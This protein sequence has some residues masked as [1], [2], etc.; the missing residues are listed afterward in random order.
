MPVP[1]V[2]LLVQVV[3][4]NPATSVAVLLCLNTYDVTILRQLHPVLLHTVTGVTWCDM[5][6]T[7]RDVR[8][9]RAALPAAEGA[10]VVRLF[11]DTLALLAR[12]FGSVTPLRMC[13][14][15]LQVT[16]RSALESGLPAP[17]PS[18]L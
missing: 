13:H 3:S 12:L 1:D 10:K 5:T 17:S 8:R 14:G 7:I 11:P 15:P 2:P 6:A 9:W 18:A 4:G 16:L